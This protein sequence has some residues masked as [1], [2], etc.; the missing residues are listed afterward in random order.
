MY[1]ASLYWHLAS[2][3]GGF[4]DPDALRGKDILE[5]ACMR[6]GGARYLAEV[7]GPRRYVATDN[8]EEHVELCRR[9][10]SEWPGL[11]FEVAEAMDLARAFPE[12]ASFDVVLCIQAAAQFADVRSFVV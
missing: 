1:G 10:H 3:L 4:G 8:V 6:G 12:G 7:A 11:S 2:T 9:C 5:V